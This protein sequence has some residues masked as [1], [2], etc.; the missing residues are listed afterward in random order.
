M[1]F[2]TTAV[3]LYQFTASWF[4]PSPKYPTPLGALHPKR[5]CAIRKLLYLF[6][7][8]VAAYNYMPAV[9]K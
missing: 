6:E 7:T 9:F 5:I 4:R 3:Q 1:P 8:H 2:L